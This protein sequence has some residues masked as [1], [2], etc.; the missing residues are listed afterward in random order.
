EAESVMFGMPVTMRIPRV[1]G[2][3]LTGWLREG[4]L[5]TDLALVVTHLLRKHDIAN[6]FV[7]FFGP[8][9]ST[10]SIG[11]RAVIANM[12]PEFGGATGY[13]P[14]DERV[15]EYLAATGRTSAHVMMVGDYARR[16][17][18]WFDPFAAPVYD[19]VIALD[20]AT[21]L[22]SLAG[23][24]R[25]Q[26][27][28]APDKVRASMGQ[29][30]KARHGVPGGA[31]AIAAITSC[32]N[33]SDPRLLIAAGLLAR[34]AR[35]RGLTSK[36]WV[37]TVLAPGSPTTERYLRRAG[38]LEDLEAIGFAIAGYGCT[39]CIGNS[40]ELTAPIR[41]AMEAGVRP[42][43][44]I[45][46][47]RNFPGRIHPALDAGFLAAPPLVVA[48]A[49]AGDVDRDILTEEIGKGADGTAVYLADI[50][51]SGREIDA[52][53]S[54]AAESDDYAAA[55]A[56]AERNPAWA[57]LDAPTTPLY[58]WDPASTYLRRPPFASVNIETRLGHYRAHPLIVLGDDITTDHISPAGAIPRDSEAAAYLVERGE[59]P[60]DLNVFSSRRGNW[61][62]M[63]RGLFTNKAVRNLLG[64]KLPPGTTLHAPSRDVML[65]WD[66]AQRYQSDA[67]SVVVV[68]G[69][70]YGMGSS[71]D[72]AAKGVAL[73]GARAVLASSFERI[74]RSNLVNM[75]ILPLRLLPGYH[76]RA[77]AL[78]PGDRI[79]IDAPPGSITP[80]AG[81]PVTVRRRSGDV[82]SF[83][84]EAQ[85]ETALEAAI[86]Q[87]GGIIPMIL[88]EHL[89]G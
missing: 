48:Y 25:P 29:I 33:T 77:L 72:W 66:A 15:L 47:N 16:N 8:A 51:P 20:L 18:L 64:D 46:G 81:V 6:R 2:V 85:I 23:P 68:A 17:A 86:L 37:K 70:R 71:R 79:E 58:P 11:E 52:A 10:L 69:E 41:S 42:A 5:A 44:V 21:V 40:G 13:F 75:G 3:K 78:E 61:E 12:A 34:K 36:S 50:W 7:E 57:G 65:L 84:A 4:V 55:Y 54:S 43:A 73:L 89:S 83:E 53:L 35:A 27:L 19:K 60:D 39:V 88:R 67:E 31:V 56:A 28:I 62:V 14:I 1:V 32:T 63:V 76:P 49:L 82:V 87:S 74:H 45:S 30:G 26:D 22:T 59:N 9:V 24:A 38:L 80:Q